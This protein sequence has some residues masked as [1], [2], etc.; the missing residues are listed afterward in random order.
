MRS[1]VSATW[2]IQGRIPFLARLQGRLC[3]E[4]EERDIGTA[5][6]HLLILSIGTTQVNCFGSTFVNGSLRN[7]K[8]ALSQDSHVTA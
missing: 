8:H 6:N 2:D 5:A 4:Y 3:I 7:A 1:H